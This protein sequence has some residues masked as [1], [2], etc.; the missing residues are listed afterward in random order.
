MTCSNAARSISGVTLPEGAVVSEET[1]LFSSAAVLS[2]R[3][4]SLPEGVK[5]KLE[6]E[7]GRK[8]SRIHTKFSA[9]LGVI[10]ALVVKVDDVGKDAGSKC[11]SGNGKSVP[12]LCF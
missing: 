7:K 11:C 10:P 3:F 4:F 12:R 5:S 9:E 8:R 1:E 2:I 6:K